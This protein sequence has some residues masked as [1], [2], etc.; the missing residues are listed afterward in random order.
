MDSGSA[1]R[2]LLDQD[3]DEPAQVQGAKEDSCDEVRGVLALTLRR[4][5]RGL[6][7]DTPT[8]RREPAL[9]RVAV[10]GAAAPAAACAGAACGQRRLA[11]TKFEELCCD[12]LEVLRGT[13]EAPQRTSLLCIKYIIALAYTIDILYVFLI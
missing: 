11:V 8:F 2:A 3:H 6:G 1:A 4:S 10:A 9:G 12:E 5:L 13:L 7:A